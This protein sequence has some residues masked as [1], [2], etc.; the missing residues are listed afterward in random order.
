LNPTLTEWHNRFRQQAGWTAAVREYLFNR[1]P[2]YSNLKILEV[3]SGTGAVLGHFRDEIINSNPN[4]FTGMQSANLVGVDI[5]Q[6]FLAFAKAHYPFVFYTLADGI[7]LPFNDNTFDLSYTH[8]FLMWLSEPVKV[9]KEIVRVT[10][11][12]CPVLSLAEPDYG[13]RIDYPDDFKPISKAQSNSLQMQGAD[14]FFGRKLTAHLVKAGLVDIETGVLGG[15]WNRTELIKDFK[16]EWQFLI[17]DLQMVN[18][19]LD[20]EAFRLKEEKYRQ[21]GER[22]LFV[23]TFYASGKKPDRVAT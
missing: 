9:L 21:E 10:K 1:I 20:L 17:S 8:F 19:D 18:S 7:T 5:N 4:N 16:I 12:G 23:P 14:P 11:P 22:V 2:D 6:E 15:N 3:G 13:G